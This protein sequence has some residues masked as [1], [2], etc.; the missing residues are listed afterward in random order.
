MS[1]IDRNIT[2]IN[3]SLKVTASDSV[4]VT[5]DLK[6]TAKEPPLDSLFDPS[7]APPIFLLISN[8]KDQK[9]AQE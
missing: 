4:D 8:E 5:N 9:N 3:S 6:S 1:N 7:P 2:F